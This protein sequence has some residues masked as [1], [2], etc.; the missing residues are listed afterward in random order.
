MDLFDDLNQFKLPTDWK[1]KPKPSRRPPRPKKGERFLKG[2]IPWDW[3][4]TAMALPGSAL[5]VGLVLWQE[6]GW[7]KSRTVKLRLRKLLPMGVGRWSAR[8]GLRRLEAAGLVSIVRAPGCASEVILREA[9][10]MNRS[11]G[12]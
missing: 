7:K 6:S 9:P 8:Q 12:P 3:I 10:K 4:E 11:D 5:F 2:P 1:A